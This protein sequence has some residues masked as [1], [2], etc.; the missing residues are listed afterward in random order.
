[1]DAGWD[2]EAKAVMKQFTL[3]NA[4]ITGNN[5]NIEAVQTQT[6]DGSKVDVNAVEV[7]SIGVG[8]GYA[9]I[10]NKGATDINITNSDIESKGNITVNANDESKSSAKI[11]N[12][13]VSLAQA[14]FT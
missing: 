13:G 8:V 2:L 3:D 4:A 1:M 5:I 14:A 7:G 6:G 12:T 9:G 11:A 10:V